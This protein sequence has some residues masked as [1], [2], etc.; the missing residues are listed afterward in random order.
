MNDLELE[1]NVLKE[2]RKEKVLVKKY[3]KIQDKYLGIRKNFLQQKDDFETQKNRKEA[4]KRPRNKAVTYK[5][6]IGT[7]GDR[8]KR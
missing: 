2:M 3:K 4:I 1:F 8:Y 5:F 7:I 6:N